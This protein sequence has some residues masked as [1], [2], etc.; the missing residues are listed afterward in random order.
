MIQ[1]EMKQLE[2]LFMHTKLIKRLQDIQKR[3]LKM[4]END[5]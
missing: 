3:L 5:H 4:L 1:C 2:R